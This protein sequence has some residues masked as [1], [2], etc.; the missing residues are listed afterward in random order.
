VIDTIKERG[1]IIGC[2]AIADYNTKNPYGI[3]NTFKL[4]SKSLRFE[5]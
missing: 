5:G 3:K 2:G 4:V 1:R